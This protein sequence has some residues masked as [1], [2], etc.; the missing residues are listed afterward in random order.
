MMIR[1]AGVLGLLSGIMAFAFP[2]VFG[3]L[4]PAYD[5]ARDFISELGAVDAPNAGLVNTYGF[6]PTGV[7]MCVFV[8]LAWAVSP[9][10]WSAF[11]GFAG[12]FLF[13]AGYVGA[14]FFQCDAGC[15]PENPSFD[16]I[17]HS[18][19]AAPGYLLAPGFMASLAVAARGWPGGGWL[20]PLAGIGAVVSV[21]AL[22]NF[23]SDGPQAGLWQRILEACVLTWVLGFGC[24]ALVRRTGASG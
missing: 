11:F 3:G 13:A 6:L 10:S 23:L 8:I 17:L 15:R 18:L 21:V 2:V 1:V 22:S 24:Y 12:L 7:A 19:F 4:D 16:H 5:S 9:R 14:A 20:A